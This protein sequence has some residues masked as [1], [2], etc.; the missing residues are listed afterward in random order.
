M[1]LKLGDGFSYLARKPLDERLIFNTL[2]EMI[3]FSESSLYAGIIS[4]NKETNKF[5]TFNANNQVDITLGKWRDFFSTGAVNF[6]AKVDMDESS[7]TYGHLLITLADGTILDCGYIIGSNIAT[8]EEYQENTEYAKNSVL[9]LGDKFARVLN[10]YTSGIT[11]DTVSLEQLFK[12]DTNLQIMNQL[13]DDN[14]S[15]GN[16]TYSSAKILNM[17]S[18]VSSSFLGSAM[19]D[20]TSSL[21]ETGHEGNWLLI[22]NCAITAPGQPGIASW[23]SAS[24]SWNIFPMPTGEFE[25]PESPS[26]GRKYFRQ[27]NQEATEGQWVAFETLSGSDIDIIIRMVKK[28]TD[29]SSTVLKNGEIAWCVDTKE[30]VIGDGILSVSAL[31]PFYKLELTKEEIISILEY[32]PED[33]LQKGQPNGYAPLDADGIVP[34]ANLPASLTDTYSKSEIDSKDSDILVSATTLVN[35]EAATARAA[36]SQLVDD[37]TA[38]TT[39]TSVHVTQTEKDAWNDKVEKS[40]LVDYNLHLKND[41]IHVTQAD[42]D[43]WNGLNKVYYVTNVNDLPA[44][45]NTIGNLGYVQVSEPNVTPVVCDTYLWN[46]TEWLKQDTGGVTLQMTWGNIDGRPDS[47]PLAIDNAIKIAHVHANQ[48]ALN[49]VGQ[50]SAGIFT[51]DGV[52]I[53]IRA[54]FVDNHLMLPDEGI[55]DTLYV[56]Y[57]DSRVRN[58]PSISIWRNGAYQI[59]GRGTQDAPPAVGDMSIL[60]NEFFS[61]TS[62]S[63]FRI[64]V[65]QNQYFCFLPLEILKEIPGLQNQNRKITDFNNPEK[66]DFDNKF[67]DITEAGKIKINIASI[68]LTFDTIEN[69]YHYYTDIDLTQYKD[70]T[71]VE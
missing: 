7:A 22:E 40:E 69:Q 21:P 20:E 36:E 55:E 18:D 29:D 31:E 27:T 6:S 25:F 19:S 33:A 61:V 32:T 62:G 26:D 48:T 71:G 23:N 43:K 12:S 30:M 45:G 10:D 35:T 24:N 57:E 8:I 63:K 16:T 15:S 64:T 38:H 39:D 52:E 4:Y 14:N 2:D 34:I 58:Y 66:F 67:I 13:I 70:I 56:V 5:Y 3:N 59:L 49:K 65:A 50:T 28:N 42:K 60:Q 68:P 51:Y 1:S 54:V 46:G 53:G 11:S 9:Y 17:L 47:S 37:L 41:I 44:E